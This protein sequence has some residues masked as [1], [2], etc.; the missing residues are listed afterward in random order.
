MLIQLSTGISV[1][2]LKDRLPI[3]AK[4]LEL[5]HNDKY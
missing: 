2:S 4:N 5:L 1:E 3:F